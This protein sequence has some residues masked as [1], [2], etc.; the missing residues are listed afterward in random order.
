MPRHAVLATPEF[1]RAAL[2]SERIRI[3]CMLAAQ[4]LFLFLGLTRTLVPYTGGENVGPIITMLVAPF[5]IYEAAVLRWLTRLNVNREDMPRLLPAVS[6]MVECLFPIIAM[7]TLYVAADSD[8][9]TL[10]VSPGYAMIMVI[11]ALSPLQLDPTRSIAIG[12]TGTLGYLG[13]V[14]GFLTTS[15]GVSPHPE[16]MY[17]TM[18][19][20][21]AVATA[22]IT[23]VTVQVRR[24]VVRAVREVEMRRQRDH[25]RRDMEIAREIQQGL[26]PADLPQLPGYEIAAMSRAAEHAGGDFYDWQALGEERVVL[27]LGD[28][29]G[30]GVGPALVAAACRAYVRAIMGV[31]GGVEPVVARVNEL[32][33]DDLTGGRFVT[34]ALFDLDAQAHSAALMS[35]GHG[36]TLWMHGADGAITSIAAQGLPLGISADGDW[37]NSFQIT[38][39]PGD[40]GIILSDGFFEAQNA[41]RVEFGLE[42]LQGLLRAQRHRA[43]RELLAEMDQ[44]VTAW[45]GAHPQQDDMTAVVIKRV[46]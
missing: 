13:L 15:D 43:A 34:L 19:T 6:A 18:T 10:L 14:I 38:F 31:G 37:D 42:R 46:S 26:L 12:T 36:P 20:L 24:Y 39:D 5:I 25:L 4:S 40:W 27:A 41:D 16:T 9:Y 45:V 17:F 28:V 8:A 33:C 3:I 21:L 7:L 44:A 23:L 32:L 29:T 11:I 22:S 2:R 1:R 30:H 35:A